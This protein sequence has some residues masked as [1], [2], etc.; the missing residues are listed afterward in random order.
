MSKL[1]SELAKSLYG[2][3]TSIAA[4]SIF[5]VGPVSLELVDPIVTAIHKLEGDQPLLGQVL[6]MIK[7]ME[8]HAAAFS[9]KYPE[10]S[11]GSRQKHGKQPESTSVA[12]I[13]GKRLRQFVYKPCHAAAFALDPLL[14]A[15]EDGKWKLPYN[16]LSESERSDVDEFVKRIGGEDAENELFD[17]VV[18]N[19][20]C[21]QLLD[22]LYA[23][24]AAQE[25]QEDGR[26]A[27]AAVDKRQNVFK[28]FE[29]PSARP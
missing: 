13:F 23:S 11:T 22:K 21:S 7:S 17:L 8:K 28:F 5:T 19:L 20:P 10:W 12:D 16:S 14:F 9:E 6:P 4:T 25:V 3:V 29:W 1:N 26:V 18:M 15:L 2:V 24:C 27:I